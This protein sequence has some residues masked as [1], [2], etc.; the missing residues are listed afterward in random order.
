MRINAAYEI[1]KM[2]FGLSEKKECLIRPEIIN[3]ALKLGLI[4]IREINE[5]MIAIYFDMINFEYLINKDQV[6]ISFKQLTTPKYLIQNLDE[7]I[8][9]GL[10]HSDFRDSFEKL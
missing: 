10:G 6:N 9:N 5:A 2:W 4:P 1:K 3:S 7:L 8:I